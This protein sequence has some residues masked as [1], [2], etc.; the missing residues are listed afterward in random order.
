[1]VQMLIKSLLY[2]YYVNKAYLIFRKN[3]NNTIVPVVYNKLRINVT[4]F[5]VILIIISIS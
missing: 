1:M 2:C 5:V 3:V 4:V